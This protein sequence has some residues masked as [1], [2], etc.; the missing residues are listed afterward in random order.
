MNK[1]RVLLALVCALSLAACSES[2]QE[3][4]VD[5]QT[6]MGP[7][8]LQPFKSQLQ[9][10]LK[11]GLAEGP[12]HAI[13]ACR[14]KAPEIAAALSTDGVRVGRASDKLRNPGNT[15]PEWVAPV[16][17]SYLQSDARQPA[18]VALENGYIGYAEPI[19]VQSLCLTCHG[20]VLAPEVA[21]AIGELYPSD[22][23]TG[24]KAGDLRGVFWVEYPTH[25]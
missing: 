5:E 10:A 7:E 2:K 8:L 6:A 13:D 22:Q 21:S 4:E 15:G 16:L 19:I 24:Y 1:G 14:I 20:E 9:Q 25:K 18:E 12:A 17:D 11:A 3:P 23:A